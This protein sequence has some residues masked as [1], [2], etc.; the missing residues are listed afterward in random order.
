[1]KILSYLHKDKP[2]E[3]MPEKSESRLI[4]KTLAESPQGRKMRMWI[5]GSLYWRD[6]Y[7]KGL[8]FSCVDE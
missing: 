3:F 8:A 7:L 5:I 4:T 2:E 1:M 6:L